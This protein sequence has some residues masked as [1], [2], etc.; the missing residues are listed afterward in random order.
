[1]SD[2]EL[3]SN[4]QRNG[5]NEERKYGLSFP[6]ILIGLSI[7][8]LIV[9]ADFPAF[10]QRG[11]QLPGPRFFPTILALF[12]LGAGLVEGFQFLRQK[13]QLTRHLRDSI[14]TAKN[15]ML[16]SW[17]AKT[18]TLILSLLV[19]FMPLI[20]AIGFI[21]GSLIVSIVIMARLRVPILHNLIV[22]S[23][24][25]AIIWL[26]FGQTFNVPLPEGLVEA[27]F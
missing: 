6:L 4:T 3:K 20:E 7:F 11:Q 14:Q 8:V 18:V 1:M 17:G 10:E 26:V 12:L 25:I 23:L 21:A 24:L 27:L 2:R 22:S 15:Q 13:D 5:E 19:L 9:S 16:H